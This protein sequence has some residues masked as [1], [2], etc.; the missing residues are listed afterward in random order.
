MNR[1]KLLS[2]LLLVNKKHFWSTIVLAEGPRPS[3]SVTRR[4]E[5]L[6]FIFL[7]GAPNIFYESCICSFPDGSCSVTDAQCAMCP[8]RSVFF[9]NLVLLENDFYNWTLQEP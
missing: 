4:E 8:K 5:C 1:C 3:G 9:C 6:L 7:C 2:R